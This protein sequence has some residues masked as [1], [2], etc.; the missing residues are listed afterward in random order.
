MGNWRKREKKRKVGVRRAQ[1][2]RELISRKS[3]QK[4]ES[5]RKMIREY[6]S[7]AV[8]FNEARVL[9][10]FG[11]AISSLDEKNMP[12]ELIDKA[13]QGLKKEENQLELLKNAIAQRVGWEGAAEALT[14]V[15]FAGFLRRH[16][17]DLC[18]LTEKGREE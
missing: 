9:V 4:K 1:K 8:L 18:V 11:E 5:L 15:G 14:L 7:Q 10:G 2:K 6:H 16:Y 12:K 17:P 3:R 13:C